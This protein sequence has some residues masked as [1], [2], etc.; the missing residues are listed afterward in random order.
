MHEKTAAFDKRGKYEKRL[1]AGIAVVRGSAI[2]F[3]SP[4][5]LYHHSLQQQIEPIGPEKSH[6][7]D[8]TKKKER[9]KESVS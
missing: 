2:R 9:K 6:C 3:L 8:E 4:G 1:A 7:P 5:S